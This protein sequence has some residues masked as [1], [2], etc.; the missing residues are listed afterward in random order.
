MPK[1]NYEL[2]S[3]QI[4]S[5]AENLI[6]N[7]I[8]NETSGQLSPFQ[9]L[10][11]DSGIDLLIYDKETGKSL[12]LQIKARTDTLYKRGKNERGNTVH[13][14]IRSVT[15]KN[16][17]SAYFLAILLSKDLRMTER[18]W[19]IPMKDIKGLLNKRTNLAKYIMRAN[20]NL[21]SQDKFRPYQCKTIENVCRR[22]LDIFE[23]NI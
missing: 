15:L 5:I 8:M 9:P 1:T 16:K 20:K 10:A 3:T 14:E 7:E 19:L 13:F 23:S 22:I 6:A 11:D 21:T 18:A 4:G 12:P 2:T 17:K